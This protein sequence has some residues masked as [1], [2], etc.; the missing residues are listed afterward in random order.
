MK[1]LVFI[2]F[3][4]L[5]IPAALQ[6]ARLQCSLP[7]DVSE[8]YLLSG[9][10]AAMMEFQKAQFNAELAKLRAEYK[11]DTLEIQSG[12]SE[13]L[14][15]EKK[16]AYTDR[17]N[18]IRNNY[19]SLINITI[20]SV[21]ANINPSTSSLGDVSF[22]FTAKNNS[23]RIVTDIIYK[24]L[25]KGK[26]LTTTT[27]LVLEFIDPATMKSGL[28]AHESMTNQGHGPE[29]F[30]F[31]IGEIS[32]EDLQGIQKDFDKK[33]GISIMDM[34]FANQKGYKG[35]FKPLTFNEAFASQLNPLEAA[36]KQAEVSSKAM[37]ES[38]IQALGQFNARKKDVL[39]RMRKSL[40]DLKKTSV[41]FTTRPD[42]KK[43]FIFEDVPPGEYYVYG[44]SG[45]GMAVFEK[46]S[47]GEKKHKES[48]LKMKKDP[49]VP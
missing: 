48:Y 37:K 23:D 17:I 14:I 35:Q 40:A 49:F 25:I 1:R 41:R 21:Q 24:P 9:G 32:Q 45:T 30:S 33:F 22:F 39:A 4:I 2:V 38:D 11:V 31:F 12:K 15:S 7:P 36:M 13:E 26:G 16:K 44:R 29:K 46:I 47:L 19:L 34:H 3:V 5:G 27:S 28:G 20:H 8:A 42:K 10:T 6:A 18:A 43:R